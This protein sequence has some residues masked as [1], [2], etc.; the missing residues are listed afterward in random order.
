MNN[1]AERAKSKGVL[2]HKL[3]KRI[4]AA[5]ESPKEVVFGVGNFTTDVEKIENIRL[6]LAAIITDLQKI[7]ETRFS[8]T[9][10]QR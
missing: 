2:T 9:E 3:Q 7:A 10:Y 4:N 8:G 5:N 6:K 1:L